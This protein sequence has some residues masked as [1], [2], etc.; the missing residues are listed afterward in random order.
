MQISKLLDAGIGVLY[1]MCATFAMLSPSMYP[2]LVKAKGIINTG[3][4]A[5]VSQIIF[6]I[7]AI[8]SLFLPG[9]VYDITAKNE[10][11]RAD[12]FLEANH[13]ESFWIKKGLI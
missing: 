3:I 10:D 13:T 11:C 4:M 8:V 2:F 12:L 1:I 6:I 5:G 7:I 9:T